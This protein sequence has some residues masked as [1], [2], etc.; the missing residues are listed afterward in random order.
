MQL[1][2]TSPPLEPRRCAVVSGTKMLTADLYVLEA[3]RWCLYGLEFFCPTD[4]ALPRDLGNLEAKS[5]PQ[6]DCCVLQNNLKAF[7]LCGRAYYLQVLLK[8]LA[9]C[10]KVHY[11]P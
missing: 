3:V 1:L 6:T 2:Q 11:F 4:A 8:I 5:T 7:F 10:D 9:Y